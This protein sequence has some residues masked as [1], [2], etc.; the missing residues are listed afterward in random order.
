MLALGP[1]DSG[2]GAPAPVL[3]RHAGVTVRGLTELGYRVALLARQP[4]IGE[5]RLAPV[6][7]TRWHGAVARGL[8]LAADRSFYV[9]PHSA[10][11][12]RRCDCAPPAPGLLVRAAAEQAIDL[13]R[14][15]VVARDWNWVRAAR[16]AGARSIGLREPQGREADRPAADYEVSGVGGVLPVVRAVRESEL[17]AGG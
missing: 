12:E 17:S 2:T 11:A 5:G 4:E 1:A 3:R 14:S 8:G 7:L 13:R 9:C 10:A 16:R 6:E 15:F